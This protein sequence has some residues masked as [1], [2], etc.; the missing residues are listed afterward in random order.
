MKILAITQA[1]YGS[2]RFP[3]KILKEVNGQSLLEIHIRR[4]LQSKNIN[5]FIVATTKEAGAEHIINI[6]NKLNVETFQGSVDDVLDRFYKAAKPEHPDYIVRV[7]SDCPLNDPAVIDYIIEKSINSNNDYVSNT[8]DPTYPNGVDIEVFT[9]S[10]LE[11]AQKEATLKSDREHVTPYIWRNSSFKG[12]NM[13][14]SENIK[15]SKD[16]SKIR[17][18]VDTPEDF[19]VVKELIEHLGIEKGFEEYVEYLE[20]HKEIMDINKQHIRNEGYKKSLEN[21]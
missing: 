2:T 9:F 13:F 10:A 20:N 12:G 8:L 14:K 3:A 5:K 17:I 15:Y 6:A 21:D 1:R 16:Y 11:K 18:T 7:T 4:V 19:E